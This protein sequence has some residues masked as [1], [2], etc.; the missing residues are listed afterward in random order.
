M[1]SNSTLHATSIFYKQWRGC[2]HIIAKF[3]F[4]GLK[5]NL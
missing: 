2:K 3:N 5:D 4:I 1:I